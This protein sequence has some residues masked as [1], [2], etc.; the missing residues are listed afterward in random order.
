MHACELESR[1]DHA[2]SQCNSKHVHCKVEPIAH[3]NSLQRRKYLP[4]CA[5]SDGMNGR[6]V[7]EEAACWNNIG[8]CK[9][10]KYDANL[11]Y[12]GWCH[13]PDSDAERALGE[14]LGLGK[15]IDTIEVH[16][17]GRKITGKF[18]CMRRGGKDSKKCSCV[19]D[20]HM[21]CCSHQGHV[22]QD[23]HHLV[24]GVT[25]GK[26]LVGNRYDD[27]TTLQGCCNLCRNH[28]SCTAWE[29]AKPGYGG[30]DQTCVLQ[31][32]SY[33]FEKN[34]QQNVRETWAG[35]AE[36]A[37]CSSKPQQL[38]Q[39]VLAK[40]AAAEKKAKKVAE[41]E[42]I[43]AHRD[44]AGVQGHESAA[45]LAASS[46][47][48]AVRAKEARLIRQREQDRQQLRSEMNTKIMALRKAHAACFSQQA[49]KK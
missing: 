48:K 47:C 49:T 36:D 40:Q 31:S 1:H 43:K 37:P 33:G 17:D 5:K 24:H 22:L 29:F 38:P 18:H 4:L 15:K 42:L 20:Q 14:H 2:P 6:P 12:S 9:P 23:V 30:S 46:I 45:K 19:C 35:T 39:S 10:S 25:A 3:H 27:V 26:S 32:G 7:Q 8:G 28:P 34:P 16:H 44:H 13:L 21:P 41:E 11:D